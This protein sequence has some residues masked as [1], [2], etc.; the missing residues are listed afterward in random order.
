MPELITGTLARGGRRATNRWVT[1]TR[2]AQSEALDARQGALVP[3]A[4]WSEL[5]TQLLAGPREIGIE[6]EAGDDILFLAEDVSRLSLVSIHVPTFL[7]GRI[8][9]SARLLRERLGY[10]GELR[11]VGDILRDQVFYLLRCGF[12]A[13]LLREDQNVD[14]ALAA[15][16]DFREVY[17]VA[18]DGALP[19]FRRRAEAL[20]SLASSR[21][22]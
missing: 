3:R 8:Y 5:R 13:L 6:L 14:A 20:R 12:D 10:R 2:I 19:L 4:L 21:E 9:S 15:F 11:A 18:A 16:R 1:I 22:G 17:Q 7:D